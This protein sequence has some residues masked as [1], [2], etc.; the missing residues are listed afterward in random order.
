MMTARTLILAFCLFWT[1]GAALARDL[2]NAPQLRIEPGM[3]TAPIIDAGTD[4]SRDLLVTGALDKTVRIWAL[5]ELRLVRVLRPPIGSGNE[6]LV[7]AVALT[8]DGKIAAVGGWPAAGT[9][10][11]AV[12]LF[13]VATGRLARQFKADEP[14]VA[15][16]F[17]VDGLLLAAGLSKTGVRVWQVAGGTM[18][19]DRDYQDQVQALDFGSVRLAAASADGAVRLYDAASQ[20]AGLHPEQ[21]VATEAG[22]TPWKLRFS[23][24]GRNL[25]I[26]FEDKPAV[27]VRSASDLSLEARPDVNGLASDAGFY[28]VAWSLDSST[29]LAGGSAFEAGVSKYQVFAWAKRGSGPR[30]VE[31]SDSD[32]V[33]SAISMLRDP[34]SLVVADTSPA[35]N[36]LADGNSK[37]KK[38]KPQIDLAYLIQD[39]NDPG[40]NVFHVSDDGSVVETGYYESPSRPLRLDLSALTMKQLDA[41]TP[42]LASWQSIEGDL[43]VEHLVYSGHPDLN[44]RPLGIEPTDTAYSVDVRHKRVLLGSESA[45]SLFDARAHQVWSVPA[46]A[47]LRVAQSPDG[48]L[49][50]A[51]LRDGTVRWYRASD[52]VELLAVFVHSDGKRW[53]AFTPSEY[54]A[55]GPGG[56]DLVGWQVNNG[57]DR[58]ADFFP[59]SKFR[60]RFDRP[61]VVSLVLKTLDETE[62][63]Q[64]AEAA[65]AQHEAPTPA[66]EAAEQAAAPRSEAPKPEASEQG[67]AAQPEAPKPEAAEQAAAAQPE[68]P[69]PEASEQAATAQH[70]APKPA[71]NEAEQKRAA[72]TDQ[73]PQVAIL[74][75]PPGAQLSGDSAELQVEVR[76]PTGRPLTSIEARVNAKP[77]PGFEISEAQAMPAAQG[78]T[79]ERRRIV[80]PVPAGQTAKLQVIAR[81]GDQASEP[82]ILEVKGRIAQPEP[83]AAPP[84]A[85]LPTLA[86]VRVVLDVARDDVGHHRRAADIRQALAAAGLEVADHIPV[87]AQRPGPSIGYYF[88]SDRNA[89]AEV[90]HLLEPLLGAVDPV[91]IRKRGSIP[92]PGTI[93]IAIP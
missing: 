87:D 46:P 23:P 3:H 50:E 69:K 31:S 40:R 91:A 28:A 54:Y 57:P 26:A 74:S 15:L 21:K 45:I 4:Q 72:P 67:A 27:E 93:E 7:G 51:A 66:P 13:D 70:E 86:P 92:E 39:A 71:A 68:A 59:A 44:G 37:A 79:V 81:S 60:D 34:D 24:D 48:R 78:E 84:V 73:A 38:S 12:D 30:R 63:V 49:V 20:D 22:R 64:Q 29:V 33:I 36:V 10:Q 90:S 80:V 88:Q 55:A 42:G 18:E 6:G 11:Y 82:A 61:D 76:Y 52:G 2:P 89:A 17:S 41:P 14:V 5:P 85:G 35:I 8:P 58:A 62:A 56:E 9:G 19:E 1:S 43:R 75:P 32:Q 25:A 83:A 47:A 65:T 77:A 16:A 53:V